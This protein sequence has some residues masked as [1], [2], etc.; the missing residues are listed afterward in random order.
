[1]DRHGNIALGFD[2]SGAAEDPSIHYAS[3]RPSDPLG[4]LP[5]SH[6]EISIIEGHGA[7]LDDISFGYYSQ[8]TVD[9]RDGCTFW[10][11][12]TYYPKTTTS[13][14][15]HTRIVAFRLFECRQ[16]HEKED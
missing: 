13:N 7:Q 12:N 14:R 15:W 16:Q 2:V 3:R 11:T 9:P 10:Y 8:M 6:D 1:M 5:V 4:Q